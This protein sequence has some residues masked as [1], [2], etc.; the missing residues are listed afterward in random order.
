VRTCEGSVDQARSGVVWPPTLVDDRPKTR[1]ASALGLLHPD[2]LW[3]SPVKGA[4][5]EA[6]EVNSAKVSSRTGLPPSAIRAQLDR[7][8]YAVATR[9]R[10]RGGGHHGS[11]KYAHWGSAWLA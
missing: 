6:S 10:R 2:W 5:A 11:S 7:D 3:V 1:R 4:R 8:R 9:D